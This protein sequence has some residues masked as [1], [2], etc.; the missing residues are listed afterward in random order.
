MM[1]IRSIQLKINRQNATRSGAKMA[2]I[3]SEWWRG[4]S[5]QAM[6]I[7]LRACPVAIHTPGMDL[8]T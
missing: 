3:W 6:V 7:G 1:V 2:R 5:V 8:D 4:V